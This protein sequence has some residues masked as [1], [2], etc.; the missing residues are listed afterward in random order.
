MPYDPIKDFAPVTELD[1]SP[2]VFIATPA[3][4]IKSIKE[5]VMRAKTRPNEL[6]YASAGI[7]TTP[8]LAAE[9]LKIMAGINIT[10]I[11]YQG[12]GPAMQSVLSGTVPLMCPLCRAPTRAS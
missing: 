9:L 3:S 2:N 5:L 1:T 11:P 8:H 12:A 6:S 4:G 7:G 10:H